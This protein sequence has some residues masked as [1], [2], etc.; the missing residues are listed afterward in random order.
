[1]RF[2]FFVRRL[3]RTAVELETASADTIS[4]GLCS[5][6]L[7]RFPSRKSQSAR[8]EPLRSADDHL[9]RLKQ[10]FGRC[11]E[12]LK[13]KRQEILSLNEQ[14]RS[15]FAE[16]E[17]LKMDENRNL[18]ELNTCR[19][20]IERLESKLKLAESGLRRTSG[21]FNSNGSD[22]VQEELQQRVLGLEQ[23]LED[24]HRLNT[25]LQEKASEWEC[26]R[27]E[28]EETKAQLNELQQRLWKMEMEKENLES[29]KML[30]GDSA[31][32]RKEL[33]GLK[34][35]LT[36]VQRAKQLTEVKCEELMRALERARED[37]E[38]IRNMRRGKRLVSETQSTK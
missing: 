5:T 26:E 14:I 36:S 2:F 34:N 35:S 28:F 25:D 23:K 7:T 9:T 38:E 3:E 11:L 6:P 16:I 33:A 37:F 27:S 24:A 10:E 1:M 4:D 29:Q 20:R 21:Q 13:S 19:E 12:D 32:L 18:I 22:D 31:E 30:D 8:S 17:R 15:Q